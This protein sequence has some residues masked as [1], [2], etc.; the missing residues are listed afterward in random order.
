[1]QN[2]QLAQR[3]EMSVK[4]MSLVWDF[5]C[6]QT[7]NGI[8]FRPSHKFTLLAYADHADHLG[9][10]IW[11]AVP[12]IARKTGFEDRSV[13][14][15]TNDLEAMGLLIDDGQGPRGTNKWALPF[16]EKGDS[17]SPRQTVT[18]DKNAKSL[19]DS[20]SG[21]IPSGDSGSPELTEPEPN[22]DINKDPHQVIWEKVLE[23][24]ESGMLRA[25]IDRYLLGTQVIRYDGN[26]FVVQARDQA[27]CD[28][29]TDRIQ[30]SAERLLVGILNKEVSVSF[31]VAPV[32][33]V[34]AEVPA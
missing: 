21:D 19:G 24:L 26:A 5:K 30:R 18:G 22:T 9:K 13:Q 31:L 1:M 6:P 2:L 27:A 3:C 23:Q 11:P 25:S 29:L 17:L 10:N 8:Q 32:A 16:N 33:S 4:A 15:L 7:I 34:T 20:P 12:T 28:W 14:R